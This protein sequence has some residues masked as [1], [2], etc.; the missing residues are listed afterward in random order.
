[1][2]SVTGSLAAIETG[3]RALGGETVAPGHGPVGGAEL[4]EETAF[5]PELAGGGGGP[6]GCGRTVGAGDG[7]DHRSG[8]VGRTLDAER[9]VGNL[10]RSYAELAGAVPVRRSIGHGVREMVEFH[11][12][13]RSAVPE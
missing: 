3:G 4:L 1:M 8:R 9:I 5:L 11:G 7:P 2:G 12:V 10:H 13:S 6:R